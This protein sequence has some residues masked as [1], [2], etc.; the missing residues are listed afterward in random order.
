MNKLDVSFII[1]KLFEIDRLKT[2]LLT[3]DQQK[4]FNYLPR[5]AIP[6]ILFDK[7]SDEKIK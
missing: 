4:L 3:Q 7:E 6:D 1:T 2:V 5:P